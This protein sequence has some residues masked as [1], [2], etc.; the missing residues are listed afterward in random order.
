MIDLTDCTSIGSITRAHGVHGQFVLVLDQVTF[1]DIKKM[2]SVFIEIDGLPVPFF[3]SSFQEKTSSSLILTFN[4]PDITILTKDLI[5]SRVY[6]PNSFLKISKSS[7]EFDKNLIGYTI[8]D[9]NLG[10]IG[11]VNEF[12]SIEKNPLL[13]ILKGKKEILI[14]LQPHFITHIDKKTK[15]IYV[16]L[17]DGLIDLS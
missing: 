9:K 1:R 10:D 11:Q 7:A 5:D 6:I 4:E 2:E 13:K 15:K 12:I 16:H 3:I 17:P 14:P 8:K